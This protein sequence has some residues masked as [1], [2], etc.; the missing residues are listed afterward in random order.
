M[1]ADLVVALHF[2]FVLF[3]VLGG[4]LVLRWPRLAYL[5]I[6]AAIWGVLIEFAGWICPLTP[7]ENA[8]RVRAG[9]AGYQGSFVEHY[10]LPVLYPSA[11][12]RNVQ[13]LLGALVLA[14]NL[15]IYG[16]LLRRIRRNSLQPSSSR[17]SH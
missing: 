5:H 10:I 2:A 3:V 12:T 15:A 14:L 16:Y 7:L 8:L 13:F 9:E 17:K 1:L 11:L 4:L 6:P